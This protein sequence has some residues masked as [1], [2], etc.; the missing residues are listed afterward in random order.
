MEYTN[1]Q[2]NTE[3]L[4]D[5]S[6]IETRFNMNLSF[7]RQAGFQLPVILTPNF[8]T[9]RYLSFSTSRY[10]QQNNLHVVVL[11]SLK[12]IVFIPH[13]GNLSLSKLDR[14]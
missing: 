13:D 7:I 12:F 11:K 2:G 10:N 3:V 14:L 6:L 1:N 5:N 8:I 4:L 9:C